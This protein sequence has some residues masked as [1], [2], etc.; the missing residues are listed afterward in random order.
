MKWLFKKKQRIVPIE[1][2]KIEITWFP[3]CINVPKGTQNPYI[4][5]IGIVEGLK[6]D[7]SFFLNMG[8]S[9]LVVGNNKYKFKYLD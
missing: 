9:T 3:S 4:G 2:R 8:T 1:G 5:S 6:E 7:G